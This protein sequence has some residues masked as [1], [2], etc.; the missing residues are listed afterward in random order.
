MSE[1]LHIAAFWLVVVVIIRVAVCFPDSLLARILF[2]H[3][4]PL[5]IRDEPKP[6]YLLRCAR[7][8]GSWFAQAVLFFVTGWIALGWNPSLADSLSFLVLWA[9]VIPALAAL[10]LL[11]SLSALVSR[12]W[13][14]HSDRMRSAPE[15]RA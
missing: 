3:H 10:A 11:G 7:F 6:E 14:K 5:P 8:R 2:S 13:H 1:L 9:V 12:F 15:S 4:G